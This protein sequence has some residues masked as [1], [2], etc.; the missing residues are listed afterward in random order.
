MTVSGAQKAA[1]DEAKGKRAREERANNGGVEEDES[2]DEDDED[3]G[4]AAKK[5]KVTQE[6]DEGDFVPL[7]SR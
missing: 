7:R 3:E 1:A 6:K 5:G 2:D 4:P